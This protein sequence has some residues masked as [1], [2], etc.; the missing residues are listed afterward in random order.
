MTATNIADWI[1]PW[2][3]GGTVG[4][5][6]AN[7]P[8]LLHVVP[9]PIEGTGWLNPNNGKVCMPC[10]KADGY[11]L[12]DARC[13]TCRLSLAEEKSWNACASIFTTKQQAIAWKH[14]HQCEPAVSLVSPEPFTLPE[15]DDRLTLFPLADLITVESAA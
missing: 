5:T 1:R 9:A 3:P 11:P 7:C 12:W 15:A 14:A 2:Y 10:L 8:D 13:N 4:H 6:R